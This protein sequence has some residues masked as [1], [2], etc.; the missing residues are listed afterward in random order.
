MGFDL[1]LEVRI[2]EKSTNRVI[3]RDEWNLYEYPEC[4]FQDICWWCGWNY[5]D[6]RD[7]MIAVSNRSLQTQYTAQE[8]CIPV[9]ETALREIYAY[10]LRRSC[11]PDDEAFELCPGE[12]RWWMVESYEKMNLNNAMKLHDWMYAIQAVRC[13]GSFDFD[14]SMF[15]DIQDKQRLEAHPD[16]YLWE[17]Q[18]FNSY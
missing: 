10:L 12:E 8:H 6:I 9:P 3:T 11:V 14:D 4:G 7:E 16:E 17:Y 18:I 2:R 1:Y 13:G 5:C 15:R